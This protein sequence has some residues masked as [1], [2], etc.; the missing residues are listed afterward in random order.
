M[1]EHWIV[2]PGVVG[3]S[4]ITHPIKK[5]DILLDISLFYACDVVRGEVPPISDASRRDVDG[6]Q[7]GYRVYGFGEKPPIR[8]VLFFA[9]RESK[10]R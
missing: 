9:V 6:S 3:S 8:V 2:V 4:P 7:F 5:R 1:A 10:G